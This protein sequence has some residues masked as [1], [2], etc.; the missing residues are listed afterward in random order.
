MC[1]LVA[2][3]YLCTYSG[4]DAQPL[5]VF[6]CVSAP[7][8]CVIFIMVLMNEDMRSWFVRIAKAPHP[9]KPTAQT[10]WLILTGK[11][12]THSAAAL[13]MRLAVR[14]SLVSR[15]VCLARYVLD[16]DACMLAHMTR[17]TL[18]RYARGKA[19]VNFVVMRNNRAQ[20]VCVWVKTYN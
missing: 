8:M 20:W 13:V 11:E 12:T 1:A 5:D 7:C 17:C 2:E 16:L 14:R 18:W 4:P 6:V 3:G 19:N 15:H 10:V 9:T